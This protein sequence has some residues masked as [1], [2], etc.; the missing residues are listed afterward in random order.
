MYY[1][2][3]LITSSQDNNNQHEDV[4]SLV[5]TISVDEARKTFSVVNKCEIN[6]HTVFPD[7]Q[8]QSC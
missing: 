3:F 4:L 2:P 6:F 7:E 5:E 1:N 8:L